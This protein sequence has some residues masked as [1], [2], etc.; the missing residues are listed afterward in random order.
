[1]KSVSNVCTHHNYTTEPR[2]WESGGKCCLG[3]RKTEPV[4]SKHL[5]VQC[6]RSKCR[7]G[8]RKTVSIA[9]QDCV[10][11]RTTFGLSFITLP[12][13]NAFSWESAKK[14]RLGKRKTEPVPSK[15]RR[16]QCSRPKHRRSSLNNLVILQ[17][18]FMN[19]VSKCAHVST[20]HGGTSDMSQK[21]RLGKRETEPIA[22]LKSYSYT[23]YDIYKRL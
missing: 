20:L 17:C 4:S 8:E 23:I 13:F 22:R 5:R 3:K 21:C 10:V 19:L 11:G 12:F 16:V 1:M 7:L 2:T 15:H 6:S 18:I 14:F 9:Q